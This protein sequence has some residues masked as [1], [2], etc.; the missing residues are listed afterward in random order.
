MVRPPK[1]STRSVKYVLDEVQGTSTTGTVSFELAK[2][3]DDETLGQTNGQDTSVP[4]GVKIKQ[5]NIMSCWG[6]IT[7]VS[8][9][10]HWSIQR[11]SS[12]QNAIDPTAVGGNALRTNVMMQGMS[13]IGDRQNATVDIKYKVPKKF[14]RIRDGDRWMFT[15]KSSTNVDTVKQCIYKV[16]T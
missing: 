3:V 9:F 14:W 7:G 4:T 16:F 13:C 6:S 10:L 5:F 8:T 12:S 1:G 2:G 15:T 11:L